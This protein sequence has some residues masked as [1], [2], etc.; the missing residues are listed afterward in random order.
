[1]AIVTCFNCGKEFEKL[2]S[3]IKRSK[4]HFCCMQCKHDYVK[5]QTLKDKNAV[6][7]NCGKKFHL[8]K[9]YLNKKNYCCK[10]CYQDSLNK[11]EYIINGNIT[12]MIINTKK[13]KKVEAYIDTKNLNLVKKYSWS[14]ERNNYISHRGRDYYIK[15]H[16]LITNCPDNKVVDHIDRNPLNNLE[17]NLRICTIMENTQNKDLYNK[18]NKTSGIKNIFWDKSCNCWIVNIIVNY[19]S[20]Y[21]GRF[22]NLKE[23]IKKA[24]IARKKYHPFFN[25]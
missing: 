8:P 14:L 12:K 24:K 1:M 3:E 7:A 19:K 17:S 23:A 20:Y 2:N 4:K 6:C 15:L 11:T 21:I 9:S 22:K 13:G 10:K 18:N 5:K 16:R 25:Q